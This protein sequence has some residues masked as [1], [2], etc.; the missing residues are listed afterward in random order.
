MD[1]KP[2][3]TGVNDPFRGYKFSLFDGG[4]HVPMIVRWEGKVPS[5]VSDDVGAHMDLFPTIAGACGVSLPVKVDGR[6]LLGSI[7]RSGPGSAR[8]EKDRIFWQSGKQ[9]AV[10]EGPWKLVVNGFFAEGGGET[11]QPLKGEDSVFLSNLCNDPG[12]A[13]NLRRKHPDV[14]DRLQTALQTWIEETQ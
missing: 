7:T 1:Q 10:R 3:Q 6:N 5:G 9:Q 4:M 14:V 2:P 11:R 13:T 12:E 8:T